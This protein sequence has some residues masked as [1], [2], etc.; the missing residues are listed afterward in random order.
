V[1]AWKMGGVIA[2]AWVCVGKMRWKI[3][4]GVRA[5]TQVRIYALHGAEWAHRA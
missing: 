4:K 3:E 5:N 1:R 2:R